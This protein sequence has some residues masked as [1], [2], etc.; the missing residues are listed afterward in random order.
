M[1]EDP[2][3]WDALSLMDDLKVSS[4]GFD[5]HIKKDGEGGANGTNVYDGTDEVPC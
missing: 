1:A 5:Y 4:P 3:T 2:A